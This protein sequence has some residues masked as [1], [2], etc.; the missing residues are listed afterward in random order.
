[1]LQCCLHKKAENYTQ[2]ET[3]AFQAG[4]NATWHYIG[5]C[6]CLINKDSFLP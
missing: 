4:V 1:L 3:A 5:L 2:F 6:Q